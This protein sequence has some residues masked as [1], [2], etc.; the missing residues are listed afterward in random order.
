MKRVKR[1]GKY[2]AAVALSASMC[3]T[4][5]GGI[6]QE[7]DVGWR[8]VKD[9]GQSAAVEWV[10]DGGRYYRLD[11]GGVMATGWYQDL[12][13]G[14]RWYYLDPN[15]G[16]PLGAMV[17][18]WVMDN[19]RWYFQDTRTGGPQ[20]GMLTGWQWIDGK[21]YYLDPAQGG[22]LA[23]S[24]TTADG[25]QV[26]ASGAWVDG[27][28]MVV[29]EAGKGIPSVISQGLDETGAGSSVSSDLFD[30]YDLFDDFIIFNGSSFNDSAWENYSDSSVSLWPNNFENGNY[31]QMSED[32]RADTEAA[33][34]AFKDEYLTDGMSDFEKE[35][36]IIKWL[37]ENC[38]YECG[39]GWENS[40][41][42]GC[43]VNGR[44]QCAGYADAFLQ[45]A[46]S[47]G[48]EAR[49]VHNPT[50]AWNLIKLDGDWYHV[51]VTWEDPI[52]SRDNGYGFE[53]L[54]NKYINCEDAWIRNVSSH[55]TWQPD[56][57]KAEG[58]AYGPK[59]VQ[60]Y[61]DEG[62][63]DTS[64]AESY[65]SIMSEFLASTINED[66][67]NLFEYD[68]VGGTADRIVAYMKRVM[69]GREDRYE[70]VV[71]YPDSF[72]ATEVGSF[73][74]LTKLSDEIED[75]VNKQ[76]NEAY[77]DVLRGN[78]K[79]TLHLQPDANR[80]YYGIASATIFYM[81]GQAKKV[82]YTIHFV[83]YE[84]GEEV[85]TQTGEAEKG[86]NVELNIPDGYRWIQSGDEYGIV[87]KGSGEYLGMVVR[88]KSDDPL[89]MTVRL[90][91][92]NKKK[93]E[94][95]IEEEKI[96]EEKI[97]EEKIEEEKIEE[98]KI[99]E[100][101]IEEEKIEEEKIE[102]EKIEEEKMEEEN[103]EIEEGN[104]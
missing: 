21:C 49:Y 64:C 60:K 103:K 20:G 76:I 88:I 94:E 1:A 43:I 61:L 9:D 48:L 19:G 86:R 93:E 99:E 82:P 26:D 79:F 73:S 39:T 55:N 41:A 35:I 13:D 12:S 42:Y 52:G 75:Q 40:T 46:K 45:T 95:K 91:N 69:D 10:L 6:W 67:S 44:A 56:S 53:K 5:F 15:Q 80:R 71:S 62:V 70:I 30:D 57:I 63:I 84:T 28:G 90:C 101:K 8:Y 3:G 23:V 72:P 17:T 66:G 24:C 96:E 50:H 14:G 85:G 68:S 78:V 97:E 38:T 54:W 37:V 65:A 34:E 87:N 77:K 58:T 83:D 89:D 22:A 74:K 59:V 92:K 47:C 102:E 98:E 7:G 18:G 25:F 100:E 11:E 31:S 16:G 2:L 29:Y 81:P 27:T 104:E 36:L 51:D 33:I 4:A 32:E